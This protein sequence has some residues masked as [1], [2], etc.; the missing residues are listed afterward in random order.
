M[1]VFFVAVRCQNHQPIIAT[2]HGLWT[3]WARPKALRLVGGAGSIESRLG[4]GQVR[5]AT[6]QNVQIVSRVTLKWLTVIPRY[7]GTR[8][9]IMTNEGTA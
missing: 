7:E 1:I 3:R 6:S 8:I 5:V 9:A 2:H 4:I